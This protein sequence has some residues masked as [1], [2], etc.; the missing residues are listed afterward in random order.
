MTKTALLVVDVQR[1]FCEGGSLAVDGGAHV[2]GAI[3]EFVHNHDSDFDLIV[4]TKDWHID[5]GTHFSET[6]DFKD[7]W[8][9]HCVAESEG[10]K[11]H[12]NF[13]YSPNRI[14]YKGQYAAAYSGFEGRTSA[15]S[16]LEHY[17]RWHGITDV[18][19]VGIAFDFCVAATALDAVRLRFNTTVWADL[20]AS[21]HPDKDEE[22]T[23][24]L[25]SAGIKVLSNG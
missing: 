19:I 1:D 10:A 17:L 22:T 8:P 21:V 9:V 25:Q 2:A 13:A 7:S 6:P 18:V 4:A 3:N 14:F 20:T 12:P 16:S 15:G 5:P 23:A 24:A 11:F